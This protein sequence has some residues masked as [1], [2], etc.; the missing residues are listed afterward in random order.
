MKICI[1][2]AGAL[3]SSLGGVLTE[4]GLDV[5]LIDPWAEH[6]SLKKVIPQTTLGAVVARVPAVTDFDQD[7]TE[8][9]STGDWVK[10]DADKGIVEI[11]KK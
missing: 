7:P 5:H 6:I 8:V 9:I 2:G 10:V 1:L 4:A 11:T 3:G